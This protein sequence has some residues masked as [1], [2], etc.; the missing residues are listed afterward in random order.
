MRG[1]R[2]IFRPAGRNFGKLHLINERKNI[3]LSEHLTSKA[4]EKTSNVSQLL[5]SIM[6]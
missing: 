1:W 2:S 3:L 5:V 6:V 4:K